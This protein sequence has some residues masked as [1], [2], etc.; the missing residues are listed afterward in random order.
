MFSLNERELALKGL[1]EPVVAWEVQW[2]PE[3]GEDE[4]RIPLPSPLPEP[5]PIGLIGRRLESDGLESAL[6][7]A[8]ARESRQVVLLGGE[9]GVGKS[10]WPVPSPAMPTAAGCSGSLRPQRRRPGRALPAVRRGAG[11]LP[12]SLNED[13]LEV[14]GVDRL[15]ALARIVPDLTERYPQLEGAETADREAERWLLFG[16]VRALLDRAASRAPTVLL[17]EDLHWADA[18]TLQLLRYLAGH[19]MGRLTLVCTYRDAAPFLVASTHRLSGSHGPGSG[20]EFAFRSEASLTLDVVSFME[21]TTGHELDVAGLD[22]A[23]VLSQETAGNPFFVAEVLRHLVETRAIV[24]EDSGRWVPTKQL[25]DA[26]LP[27]SVRQVV[28]ARV[29]RLGNDA[30][31]VLTAAAVLGQEFEV[32]L[33]AEVMGLDAGPVLDVLEAAQSAALGDR[34]QGRSGTFPVLPCPGP[35]HPLRRFER[36]PSGSPPSTGRGG[37]GGHW[38]GPGRVVAPP[39]W[40]ATGSPPLSHRTWTRPSPTPKWPARM[41]STRWPPPR[42][43]AGIGEALGLLAR[44]DNPRGA[45]S[46]LGRTG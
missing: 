7:G 14:I 43:T 33:L 4:D 6:K 23:Q 40:P 17:L 8:L 24:Q 26:G 36:H 39:S 20:C 18:P 46:L 32:D 5:P 29:N 1:P 27:E 11:P 3:P 22:L 2:A 35:T 30:A 31:T 13:V 10:S 34:S 9:A 44:N 28:G 25:A 37:T 45:S 42:P 21:A 12:R 38:S 15:A 16:A 19:P 41:H